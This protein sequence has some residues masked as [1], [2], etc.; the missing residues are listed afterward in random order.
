MR[1]VRTKRGLR[2]LENDVIL[3]E[4]LKEPGPTH[5][6]F[7]VLAA[8][9]AALAP[10]PRFALLGFAGGGIV[11]P[12]RAMGFPHPVEAVD[13]DPSGE[14]L[15]R[16]LSERW[17]GDVRVAR[18]DALEWLARET[19]PFDVILED[20]SVPRPEGTFKPPASFDGLPA[21]VRA[22]LALAGVAVTNV[23]PQPGMTWDAQLRPVARPHRQAAVIEL[24]E[25]ENRIVIGGAALPETADLA[26][27]VRGALD[28][29]GSVQAR[30]IRFGAYR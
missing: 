18:M 27:R 20:L 11:A 26:R 24:D 23:L 15:F 29:I 16:G 22:H 13:L 3:S 2:L 9:V 6:L 4:L 28:R 10:G 17:A 14:A 8:A 5:C 19:L 12:L 7:D 1:I 30:R 25:Y 21:L